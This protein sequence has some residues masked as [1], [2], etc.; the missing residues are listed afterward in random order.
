MID[1]TASIPGDP[2]ERLR[3]RHAALETERSS[4]WAF[5]RELNE[6]IL[7]YKARFLQTDT[8]RGSKRSSSIINGSAT[9]AARTMASGMQAGI[10]NP[11]RPWFR[12]TVADPDLAANGEVRQWLDT[13]EERIR[14]AFA[15]SNVYLSLH[16][17]YELIVTYG[18]A[19]MY[20]EEDPSTIL[21]SFVFPIGQY[22]LAN[23]ANNEVN[24][25]F[26]KYRMSVSQVV[27]KFKLENC[28]DRV[29]EMYAC[30]SHDEWVDVVHAIEPNAE[31]APG[32]IGPKGK[33]WKSVWFE[34][35]RDVT[36]TKFLRESGYDEFP[37][38]CPRWSV[39]D[40]DVYGT[41]PGMDALGDIR[42]LQQLERKKAR[43][44]DKHVDPPMKAPPSLKGQRASLLPG[45]IT[46]VYE[47]GAGSS[48]SPAIVVDPQALPA[49]ENSV[50]QHERRIN[51]YFMVDLWLML[52][53]AEDPQKTAEEIRARQQEKMLQLGPVMERLQA[54]LLTPLI[55]RTLSILLRMGQLPKPPQ[56]LQGKD[57]T[58]QYISIMA[59]AQKALG[60]APLQSFAG[61][62]GNLAVTM[63]RP[64]VLDNVDLDQMVS[65][66]ADNLGIP[67][68]VVHSED[69]VRGIRQHRAQMQA[70]QTQMQQ[71]MAM[72]QGAKTLSQAD[73]SGDNALTRLLPAAEGG[74]VP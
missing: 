38:M 25:A 40:G 12:L 24:S 61:F 62:V 53:Q 55:E 35:N 41:S 48:F 47:N 36:T 63:Q 9:W 15:R 39:N 65:E 44:L 37:C 74:A 33:R 67:A 69:Q 22:A 71:A 28:S 52:S 11:A 16:T 70:Q 29:K 72:A 21:R 7:P 56:A 59:Q 34:A 8:N 45:E 64:D 42:G 4:W 46:Y 30:G 20:V 5:W 51:K 1:P 73:T 66:F 50:A 6:F 19:V 58:P 60:N 2:C 27:E 10:T 3:K 14:N 13:V 43:V 54:E 31:F 49:A 23:G 57:V 18:T 32:T 17:V 26:R 68:K